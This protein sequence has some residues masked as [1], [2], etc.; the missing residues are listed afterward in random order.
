MTIYSLDLFLFL[1]GT[2]LLFHVQFL[3]LLPDLHIGA[4]LEDNKRSYLIF[5]LSMRHY[6]SNI[7]RIRNSEIIVSTLNILQSTGLHF[8]ITVPCHHLECMTRVLRRY[9]NCTYE[10]C[11]IELMKCEMFPKG[12]RKLHLKRQKPQFKTGRE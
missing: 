9:Q 8:Q 7:L 5:W 2:S 11:I 10:T 1:F 6:P 3:L 4:S 12:R